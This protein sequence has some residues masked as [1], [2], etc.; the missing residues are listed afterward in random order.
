MVDHE[1]VSLNIKNPEAHA[2][3]KELAALERTSVTEAVTIS[4]REALARRRAEDAAAA[5]LKKMR[6]IADRFADELAKTPGP[7][8]WEINEDLYDELGLPK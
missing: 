7:S 4:L 8:L 6:A 5:K 3:A 1:P 2:L